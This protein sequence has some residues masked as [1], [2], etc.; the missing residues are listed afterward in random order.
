MVEARYDISK[1]SRRIIF[2]QVEP[3]SQPF[4]RYL[5]L[6]SKNKKPPPF[7]S[8][9]NVPSTFVIYPYMTALPN[10]SRLLDKWGMDNSS[11]RNSWDHSL[12][13]HISWDHSFLYYMNCPS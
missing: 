12:P 11:D 5:L 2:K 6:L 3:R 7:G 1:D 4:C 10:I 9:S 13:D 8:G